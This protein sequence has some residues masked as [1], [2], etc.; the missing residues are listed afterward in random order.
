MLLTSIVFAIVYALPGVKEIWKT[1]WFTYIIL[2]VNQIVF[3]IGPPFIYLKATGRDIRTVVRFKRINAAQVV[4]IFTIFMLSSYVVGPL[5]ELW[6]RLLSTL[7]YTVKDLGIPAP[8]DLKMLAL[9]LLAVAIIPPIC[10]EFMY[11]GVVLRA[12]ENKGKAAAI[13]MSS[14]LFGFMH[15]TLEQLAYAVALGLL[16]A[17]LVYITDSLLSGML[18]HFL[19]NARSMIVLYMLQFIKM[20]EEVSSITSS[21]LS[22]VIT[23]VAFTSL[24]LLMLYVLYQV[25]R[26]QERIQ[27]VNSDE[28][29]PVIGKYAPLVLALLLVGFGYYSLIIA[30]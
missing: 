26:K 14:L 16:M 3:M 25:S 24:I 5:N 15:G 17:A 13:V 12:Y 22:L 6:G 9:G 20:E 28:N 30:G 7:G 4:I 1:D 29:R 19:Y 10:E 27:I 21:N 8:P 11:R 18:I 2:I 23:I